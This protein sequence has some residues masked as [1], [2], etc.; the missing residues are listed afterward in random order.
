MAITPDEWKP[1]ALSSALTFN[2]AATF[3]R[4]GMVMI[5]DMIVEVPSD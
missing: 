1:D 5:V 4:P 2:Q 3:H